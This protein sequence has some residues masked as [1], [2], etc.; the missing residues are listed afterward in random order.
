MSIRSVDIISITEARAKLAELADEIVR[1]GT[2]KILT[3]NGVGQVAL[4]GAKRLDYYHALEAE[5]ADLEA[6]LDAQRGLEDIAAGRTMGIK[7]LRSR[8]ASKAKRR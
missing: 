3:R 5:H 6:L 1:D 8:V 2:E 4:I 7:A